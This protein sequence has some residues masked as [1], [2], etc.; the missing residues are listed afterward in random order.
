MNFEHQVGELLL[1]QRVAQRITSILDLDVLLEEIVSDVAQTFGYSR[2]AVLLV[3]G[4]DL[5]IAAVRGWTTNFHLKG[6][7]FRI[8]EYGMVG[9]VGTTGE[10]YYAPDVTV[11]PYYQ[12][13]ETLTRSEL[14]IPLKARGRMFG[15]FSV[16]H[17]E[18]NSFSPGRVQVLE[19]LA[20]HLSV[21]IDN[22]QMFT[23]DEPRNN[24]WKKS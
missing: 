3:D 21:A 9:H 16:Q 20:G 11:D 2:A 17:N 14:D 12:V 24:G 23:R 13:S 22:A 15:V 7:R 18:V 8:G 1:L 6:E 19:A 5:V 10:T 4:P